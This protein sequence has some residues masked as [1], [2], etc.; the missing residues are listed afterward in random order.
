MANTNADIH[1]EISDREPNMTQAYQTIR[2]RVCMVMNIIRSFQAQKDPTKFTVCSLD[3]WISGGRKEKDPV[4]YHSNKTLYKF[5]LD[6]YILLKGMRF[7][8]GTR[9]DGGALSLVA[10]A[11]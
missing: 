10:N 2:V 3:R 5:R 9:S 6:T 1:T 8:G 11:A 7:S 4:A